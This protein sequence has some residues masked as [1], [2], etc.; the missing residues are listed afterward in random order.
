MKGRLSA[1]AGAP[2]EKGA[3]DD[4]R[5][6]C[7]GEGAN[8]AAKQNDAQFLK[9]ALTLAC[10]RAKELFKA[11]LS[12]IKLLSFPS[13]YIE[14]CAN[15]AEILVAMWEGHIANCF[16]NNLANCSHCIRL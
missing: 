14:I 10:F 6:P 9:S 8:R 7:Q 12:T 13:M 16:I 15:V 11:D 2:V 1:W 5:N 3:Y 4:S